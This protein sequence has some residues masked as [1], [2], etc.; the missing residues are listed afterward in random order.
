MT[1]LNIYEKF[2]NRIKERNFIEEKDWAI[3]NPLL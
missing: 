3:L 1:I 2:I